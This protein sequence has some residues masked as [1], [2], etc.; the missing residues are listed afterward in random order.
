MFSSTSTI[1][2]QELYEKAAAGDTAAE[3]ELFRNLT[4]RFLR[5]LGHRLRRSRYEDTRE[6][7]DDLR[8]VTQEAVLTTFRI[9]RREKI[10]TFAPWAQ[11]VLD[12]VFR[13]WLSRDL[14]RRERFL[15]EE[16]DGGGNHSGKHFP[17]PATMGTAYTP[18]RLRRDLVEEV[19]R[20]MRGMPDDYRKVMV[21]LMRES[22]IG[23]IMAEFPGDSAG[24]V[25][26]RISR[27]RKKLRDKLGEKREMFDNL[28]LSDHHIIEDIISMVEPGEGST[29]DG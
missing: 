22:N 19:C 5:I 8:D 24:A 12:F 28:V 7:L 16:Y 2:L 27:A 21:M 20:A 6:Y 18:P 15:R 29:G 1:S 13:K 3:D 11:R 4:E 25:Y 17:G 14:R 9:Y 23:E 10:E 26:T